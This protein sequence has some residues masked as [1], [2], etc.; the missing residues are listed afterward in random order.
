MLNSFPI[1]GS[2]TFSAD[3]MNAVANEATLVVRRTDPR[4]GKFILTS[5]S[6]AFVHYIAQQ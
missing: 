5:I 4:R 2:A 1:I 6:Q 3:P